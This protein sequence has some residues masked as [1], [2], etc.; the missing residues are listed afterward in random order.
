MVEMGREMCEKGQKRV[1]PGAKTVMGGERS[2]KCARHAQG[3]PPLPQGVA[4]S[5]ALRPS[6]AHHATPVPLPARREGRG[7]ITMTG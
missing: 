4:R 6:A 5:I 2:Q 1:Q 3:T 7:S